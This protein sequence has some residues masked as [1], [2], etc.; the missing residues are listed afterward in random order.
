MT[1]R[2][3][4]PTP[5]SRS[6]VARGVVG[7]ALLVSIA[8]LGACVMTLPK[9]V[10]YSDRP[11]GVLAPAAFLVGTWRTAEVNGR[12]T[13]ETWK[14]AGDTMSGS[15]TT[16]VRDAAGGERVKFWETLSISGSPEGVVYHAAPMGRTP[17]TAF[18][19]VSSEGGRVVFENPE[20]DFPTRVIYWLEKDGRL[21][22]RIEG[23]QNGADRA[24]DWMY[25]RVGAEAN[26]KQ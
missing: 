17:A 15:S 1:C 21:H 22:G 5:L 16:T 13:T 7:A 12:W 18:R 3:N 20:H 26:E 25:E 14:A 10:Q 4:R 8:L 2:S 11:G 9:S 23:R 19:L 24:E 6:A